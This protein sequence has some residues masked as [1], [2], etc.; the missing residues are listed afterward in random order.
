M[1]VRLA[2]LAMILN[3]FAVLLPNHVVLAWAPQ[4][5]AIGDSLA[6]GDVTS[7]GIPIEALERA[8]L[9]PEQAEGLVIP[10]DGLG[11]NLGALDGT[12]PLH[13]PVSASGHG[14]DICMTVSAAAIAPPQDSGE[15]LLSV[16]TVAHA[17]L[18]STVPIAVKGLA[19]ANRGPPQAR[20]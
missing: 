9:T 14:C 16:A 8:G 19:P 10:C 20:I 4:N 1:G 15:P 5:A 7:T 6:S 12:G 3:A 17:L 2:L 18:S 13:L 11:L